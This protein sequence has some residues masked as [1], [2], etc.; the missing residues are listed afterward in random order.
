M[1][2]MVYRCSDIMMHLPMPIDRD[3]YFCAFNGHPRRCQI[4][5]RWQLDNFHRR[6]S[7]LLD[8]QLA[9]LHSLSDIQTRMYRW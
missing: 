5:Q 9:S 6:G 8:R 3:F 7:H 2:G 4:S 1:G